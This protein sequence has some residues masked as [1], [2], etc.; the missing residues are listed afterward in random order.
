[1]LRLFKPDKVIPPEKYE[2]VRNHKY[3]CTVLSI[4][5]N[6]VLSPIAGTLVNYIPMWVA[7]NCITFTGYT[8]NLIPSVVINILYGSDLS[9][10]VDP[11]VCYLVAVCFTVY[12]IL[13]C[14][15]GK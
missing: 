8:V 15:D 5:Y 3:N 11:W 2:N 1:M 4:G 12:Y 9:G 6:Y 7:P 10:Y 13:D 14:T